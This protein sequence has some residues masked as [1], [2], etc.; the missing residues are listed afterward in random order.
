MV[1]FTH[2]TERSVNSNESNQTM[3]LRLALVAWAALMIA[4]CGGPSEGVED[5]TAQRA[6][7]ETAQP[8]AENPVEEEKPNGPGEKLTDPDAR[9]VLV[10]AASDDRSTS[11]TAN[12]ESATSDGAAAPAREWTAPDGRVLAVGELVALMDGNVCLETPDGGGATV[13]LKALSWADRAYVIRQT[14]DTADRAAGPIEESTATFG[15]EAAAALLASTE[16]ST[17]EL[18]GRRSP[19]PEPAR[20]ADASHGSEK[21]VIPFDFVSKFDDGR[22]GAMVGDMIYKKLDREGGFIIPGSMLEVRD[23]CTS[24]ELA[25]TLDMPLENVGRIVVQDF[26]AE[27]GIWG[28]VERVGGHEWEVYDF[29]IRCVDFSR[30]GEPKIVY[31]KINVR[32]KSVSEIPHLYVKEMLDA[33]Y[34]REPGGPPRSDPLAEQNWIDNP[35]LIQ[36][37]DFERGSGPVPLGWESRGGQDREPL[38]GLVRWV[39][40][41]GGSQAGK[42]IRFTFDKGVGDGYGVMYYSKP[43][44]IEEGAKYRFECRWRTNGPKVKVFIKCYDRMTSDYKGANTG[45][46]SRNRPAAGSLGPGS[47]GGM[48]RVAD[49]GELREC[50]R[51]QQNL[52][53]PKNTWNTQAQDFTPRHTKYVP[54]VG[55]VMLYAYVGAGVVEFDDVVLKQIVPPSP[56][57]SKKTLRHSL[58]SDVTLDEMRENEERARKAGRNSTEQK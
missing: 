51:S 16:A 56:G 29:S 49:M 30:A 9:G 8:I 27:V 12:S 41:G 10:P 23:F 13:P 37:G 11:S 25:I 58:E 39:S 17:E 55:R 18:T 46:P 42:A 32:T 6:A 14:A 3:K 4:S 5:E 7:G 35:N 57:E 19:T 45:Q 48:E 15:V 24:R 21:V 28:S 54:Q 22:Y 52:Y 20:D 47:P 26:D 36:G 50:Y 40:E 43:F 2:A 53:G 33:L 38:G 31:Q 34:E 44:P 1:R